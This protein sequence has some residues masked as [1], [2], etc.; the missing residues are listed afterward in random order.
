MKKDG[1]DP[2]KITKLLLTHGHPDH[3]NGVPFFEE[4][5]DPETYI[6]EADKDRMFGRWSFFYDEFKQ[7]A[8][9]WGLKNELFIVSAKIDK[10]GG[11]YSLGSMPKT[12]PHD[13]TFKDGDIFKGDKYDLEVIHTPG[14]TPGHSCFYNESN[15]FLF[16][17]DLMDP[18]SS[19][20]PSLNLV[21]TEYGPYVKS[22]N[23]ILNYDIKAIYAP[24]DEEPYL[25]KLDNPKKIIY[26]TKEVLEEIKNDVIEFLKKNN[27]TGTKIADFRQI[28]DEPT[29]KRTGQI[30]TPFSIL[31]WLKK[32]GK[33][34]QEGKLFYYKE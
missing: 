5:C 29:W 16:S 1:L 3:I 11:W 19:Y 27:E 17:G 7:I 15:G 31:K 33:L 32:E 25:W 22:I 12:I 9:K 26:R 30:S 10:I 6:H 18:T 8:K 2:T 4:F 24:H 28:F 34:R 14:H 20:R 23:K 13:H 21:N